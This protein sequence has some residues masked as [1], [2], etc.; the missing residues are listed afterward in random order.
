MA[1]GLHLYK[2]LCSPYLVDYI[3]VVRSYLLMLSS[4]EGVAAVQSVHMEGATTY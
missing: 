2:Q 1:Y 3:V 4:G